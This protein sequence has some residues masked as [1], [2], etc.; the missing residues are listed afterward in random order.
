MLITPSHKHVVIEALLRAGILPII[1]VGEPGAHGV[2]VMG[3]HGTGVGVPSAA[4]VAA[5]KAGLVG[6]MHIPK[7]GMLAIGM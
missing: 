5:I 2:V 3:T 4:E 7:G 6:A 1:T